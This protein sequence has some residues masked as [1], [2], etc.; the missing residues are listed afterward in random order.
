MK[1]KDIMIGSIFIFLLGSLLHFTYDLSQNNIIV[2]I[3]SATNESIFE[4]T[5]LILYPIIIWYMIFYFKN[6]E[7]IKKNYL[8]SSMIINIIISIILIPLLDY[9]YTGIFGISSL[10][11]DLLIF[12]V[13][14]LFGLLIG[15]KKY[16]QSINLPWR[17][18]LII[19]IILF[20]LGTFLPPQIPFF[21]AK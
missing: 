20:I 18:Y 15:T 16:Y 11:I 12:Y 17:L 3:F 10:I 21:M 13:S 14:G 4:H 2:G 9:F 8:F 1:K 6:K 7:R 5:K 19:V